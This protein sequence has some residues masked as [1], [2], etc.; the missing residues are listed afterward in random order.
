MRST[1]FLLRWVIKMTSFPGA[2]NS[3]EKAT[4]PHNLAYVIYT[5]G[6]TGKPKGVQ[7]THRS[8][9][10]LLHSMSRELRLSSDDIFLAVSSLSFDIAALE[11]FLPLVCGARL[12]IASQDEV[13]DGPRLRSKLQNCKA[14]IMQATPATWRMLFDSAWQGDRRLRVLCGG[15]TLSPKLANQLLEGNA[16]LWNLYGPTETTIWSTAHKITAGRSS[17]NW[18]A[19]RQHRG[20][21]VG[22]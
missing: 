22:Q 4:G 16:E 11:L 14:T 15:D 13:S 5:S 21:L 20:L 6:S 17:P 19:H 3:F 2:T 10:N 18:F 12:E 8:V 7:I 9:V 1:A